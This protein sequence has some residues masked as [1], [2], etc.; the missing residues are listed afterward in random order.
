MLLYNLVWQNRNSL[1]SALAFLFQQT[2]IFPQTFVLLKLN[3]IERDR[4]RDRDRDRGRE[5]DRERQG[6][7]FQNITI[8]P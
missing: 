5:K 7:T 1:F 6:N 4:N 2:L 8:T 3:R